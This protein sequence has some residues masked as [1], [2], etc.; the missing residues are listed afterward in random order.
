MLYRT[1]NIE[2]FHR[3]RRRRF[4][5]TLLEHPGTGK[6]VQHFNP[7]YWYTKYEHDQRQE[8]P[9]PLSDDMKAVLLPCAD[10]IGLP[11]TLAYRLRWELEQGIEDAETALLM[12][13]MPGL[14]LLELRCGQGYVRSLVQAVLPYA[15]LT[16]LIEVS[17]SPG[18]GGQ[19]YLNDLAP[20]LQLPALRTFRGFTVCAD[21]TSTSVARRNL[22]CLKQLHLDS[23]P[24]SETS[25]EAVLVACPDLETLFWSADATLS[26]DSPCDGIGTTLRTYGLRLQDL[27]ISWDTMDEWGLSQG[28]SAALG[29]L[30]GLKCLQHFHIAHRALFGQPPVMLLSHLT[31]ILPFSLQTLSVVKIEPW[32]NDNDDTGTGNDS[33]P[34]ENDEDTWPVS[35]YA[36][37]FDSQMLELLRDKRYRELRSVKFERDEAF[38]LRD[39]ADEAGWELSTVAESS[40]VDPY[41]EAD[42]VNTLLATG[43]LQTFLYTIFIRAGDPKPAPG[44]PR[45]IRDRKRVFIFVILTYLCYT[46]YEADYQLRRAGDF[47]QDLGVPHSVSERELQSRFRRLTVQYHPDKVTSGSASEKAGVEAIYIHLKLAR[48]TLVDPAK[49]FAYDR[50]GPEILQWRQSK[51]I[52]DFVITGVQR[53]A[54]YYAGSGGVLVLLSMLGY[55]QQGKF[56]RYIVMASLFVVEMHTMMSPT[57]PAVFDNV[58]NP[59]LLVTGWRPPYLPF[60]MLELLRKLTLTFFIALSQLG[61]VL[62]GPQVADGDALSTQHLDRIDALAKAADQEVS[63]LAQLE[64]MPFGNDQASTKNL[65]MSLKEWLVQNTIRN[66]REVREA[67]KTVLDRRRQQ[68]HISDS[69]SL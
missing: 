61:P 29:N 7:G 35:Q 52:R 65:R 14:R 31:S 25:F 55:L 34:E 64:L 47:Y 50:F 32:N 66:D 9:M 62:Q 57:S 54:A 41:S 19:T 11:A 44:S 45:F 21:E 48:D 53:T 6:L 40:A 58:I 12:L 36:I 68:G 37:C 28:P 59:F 24:L 56:W 69:Q 17:V 20:L 2:E 23:C 4:L 26:D 43:Y 1:L 46:V 8:P 5:R 18:T 10:A 39:G 22:P 42:V 63:R 38:S 16:E 51:T 60:Q 67:I 49:R 30:Q 3:E 33:E 15:H 27:H 13:L